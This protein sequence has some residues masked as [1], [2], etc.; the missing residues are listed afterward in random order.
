MALWGGPRRA[1]PGT[2]RPRNSET[3]G[4]PYPQSLLTDKIHMFRT[5]GLRKP[6]EMWS[7]NAPT[8]LD[9]NCETAEQ[10]VATGATVLRRQVDAL[11]QPRHLEP[12][13]LHKLLLLGALGGTCWARGVELKSS[14]MGPTPVASTRLDHVGATGDFGTMWSLPMATKLAKWGSQALDLNEHRPHPRTRE[15]RIPTYLM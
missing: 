1:T 14:K 9:R 6:R 10:T 12:L 11:Q 2:P 15:I 8:C 3:F 13:L 5:N 4:I 7:P